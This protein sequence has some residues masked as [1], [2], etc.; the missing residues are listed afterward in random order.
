MWNGFRR[1]K[2]KFVILS[3]T[4]NEYIKWSCLSIFIYHTVDYI[5]IG[6]VIVSSQVN[7][8]SVHVCRTLL[9]FCVIILYEFTQK[10]SFNQKL[11]PNVKY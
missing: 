6:L 7:F 9:Q 2:L 8:T 5:Y 10:C 1:H 3:G 11:V 4:Y